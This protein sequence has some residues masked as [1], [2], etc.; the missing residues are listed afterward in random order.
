[1]GM[2]TVLRNAWLDDYFSAPRWL[3][4]HAGAPGAGGSHA[5]EVSGGG[6]ARQSLAGKMSAASNGVVIN[7]STITFPLIT[8]A[9]PVVTDF[10]IEDAASVGVMGITAAFSSA[11]LKYPGQAYQFP[12]GTIRIAIE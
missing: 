6:Y 2:T 1:M 3:S 4:L 8:E 7:T 10:G 5:F 12:P 9:Y 11:S